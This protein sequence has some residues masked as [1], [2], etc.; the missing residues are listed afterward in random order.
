MANYSHI[1][2]KKVIHSRYSKTGVLRL[3]AIFPDAKETTD[4]LQRK[5]ESKGKLQTI[6]KVH[7]NSGVVRKIFY[8]FLFRVLEEVANGELFMYPGRTRANICLKPI[9]KDRV[10]VL[11][12]KGKYD[13]INTIAS[14]G[15]IPQFRFDFGPNTMRRDISIYVPK[16][17]SDLA[18]Q[19]AE[20]G[21]LTWQRFSK[22]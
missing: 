1:N 5:R 14:G 20:E 22:I 16:H 3:S 13:N 6:Y 21:K 4:L 11:K 10:K 2:G 18:I 12:S 7:N 17:L 19:N 15:K 9:A 8:T